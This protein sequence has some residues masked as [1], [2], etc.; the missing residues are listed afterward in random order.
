MKSRHCFQLFV[1]LVL[2][3]LPLLGVA[4]R[5]EKLAFVEGRYFEVVGTDHRSVSFAN[6]LGEH[7]V[8]LCMSYL[9]A[10]R[11]D[12]PQ[13]IFVALRPENRVEFDG[14]YQIQIGARGQVSLDFRWEAA[15]SFETVCRA[16]TEAYIVRYANFN[17][18]PGASDRIRFWAVSALGSQC[19]LKL[20]PA[21]QSQYIEEARESG[22]LNVS[23]L[24]AEDLA[25]GR[26]N[27]LSPRQGYWVL[28]AL[29]QRGLRRA[30]VGALL[31]QAIAGRDV[32]VAVGAAIQPTD[33]DQQTITLEAWWQSQMVA[34][35]SQDIEHY[36]NLDVSRAWIEDL[37][38]LDA[39]RASGGELGNLMELWTHRADEALRAVLAARQQIIAL[40]L[41]RVN[42]AYFNAAQ[43]LGALY[44]T[45]LQTE[46]RF[47]FIHAFTA[48]LSDWEDTKRLH[49]KAHELL[50]TP[51]AEQ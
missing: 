31:D 23:S 34:Y 41:E 7:V 40:R 1:C 24:L 32:S 13:R 5:G 37:A 39:Y 20:R 36:E 50:V 17:Y 49:E 16:L 15:L 4:Q 21:Q 19:Y 9:R 44:E 42:P 25:R 47:E 11:H 10:G 12:F 28:Y 26:E 30:E 3:L 43:S 2:G 8:E 45:T 51:V 46:R 6:T 38:N 35:L 22:L 18:G 14:E 48:Y 33:A 27:G 29:R